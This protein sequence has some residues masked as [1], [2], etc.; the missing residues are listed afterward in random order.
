MNINHGYNNKITQ[1]TFKDIYMNLTQHIKSSILIMVSISM[2]SNELLRKNK[3]Y[4][5]IQPK[6][7]R[8]IFI[9]ICRKEVKKVV[10]KTVETMYIL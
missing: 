1:K 5:V 9:F 6:K 2:M 3:I 4:S 7:I 8:F 10:L